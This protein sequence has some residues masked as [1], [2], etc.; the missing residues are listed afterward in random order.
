MTMSWSRCRCVCHNRTR[1]RW[2]GW[3]GCRLTGRCRCDDGWEL[4]PT[5]PTKTGRHLTETEIEELAKEAE[6]G[7][8]I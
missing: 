1:P 3:L 6:R 5:P 7:Y 8:E 2:L 4:T